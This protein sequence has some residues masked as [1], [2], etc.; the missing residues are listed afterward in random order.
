MSGMIGKLGRKDGDIK[1]MLHM[2]KNGKKTGL[3]LSKRMVMDG[4]GHKEHID[5]SYH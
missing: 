3:R 2:T 1:K 5:A 4:G